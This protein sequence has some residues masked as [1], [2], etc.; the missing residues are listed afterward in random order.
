[1]YDLTP[2]WSIGLKYA[3]RLGQVSVDRENPD[4]FDNNAHLYI[5]RSDYRFLRDWEGSVEGRMLDLTDLS[6]RRTGALVA[7]YRYLGKHFKIGS[8]DNFNDFSD[9]LT[10]RSYDHHGPFLNLIGTL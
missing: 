7:I 10:D 8:G 3:Y 5:L 4:F 1:M 2:T 6:E 9:D